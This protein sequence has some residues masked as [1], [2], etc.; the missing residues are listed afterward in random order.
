MSN[1]TFEADVVARPAGL[2][3]FDADIHQSVLMNE[4][5]AREYLK[6]M[7][8]DL[9]A[10]DSALV[11][12]RARALDFA[13]REGWRAL[14]YA[15]AIEALQTELGAQY[16]KSYL[17]RILQA[18]EIER[19]L[20]LPIG[21]LPER[22]LR[23]LAQLDTPDQQRAAYQAIEG[24]PTAGKMQQAVDQIKPPLSSL[25]PEQLV[26]DDGH[27]NAI[28]A[29]VGEA[30]NAGER[31]GTRMYQQAYDHA[32][33]IHDL[34]LHNKMIALIDRATDEPSP[35]PPAPAG[36]ACEQCGVITTDMRRPMN[37]ICST[38]IIQR[39]ADRAR[40][41]SATVAAYDQQEQADRKL[42]RA[43]HDLIETSDYAGAR[44]L[45]DQVQHSTY[46]RDQVARTLVRTEAQRFHAEQEDRLTRFSKDAMLSQT[47]FKQSLA[48]IAALLEI[49]T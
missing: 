6:M 38:C 14:G 27:H 1:T 7:Q 10:A 42:M 17:S 30:Q 18:G 16:S 34:T 36:W 4:S 13:E 46:E 44:T 19:V 22:T 25:T 20:E 39:Q 49:T 48:H 24:K 26:S 23:P 3:V 47:T 5:E 21:Q 11:N 15:G 9:E 43:A 31:T 2:A 41:P 37:P 32:A 40:L 28:V 35:P 33:E 8:W 29:L 12:F 45:L